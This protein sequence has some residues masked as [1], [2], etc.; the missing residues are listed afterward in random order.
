MKII[1]DKELYL[2][3]KTDL[4]ETKKYADVLKETILNIHT[5]STI[6]LFGEWGSG[7]SSIIKTVQNDLEKEKPNIKFITYDA[8]KYQGDSFR[9]TF[10][11]KVAK[12][13]ECSNKEMQ[14][15]YVNKTQD[16]EI[17]SKINKT[18][19]WCVVV[20]ICII[21]GIC[22]FIPWLF[23][24]LQ[25]TDETINIQIAIS[26]M[27][28]VGLI[29]TFVKN[30][31]TDYKTTITYPLLF[32]PEQFGE[33]FQTIINE[34][35]TIEEN[36]VVIVVDNLDRCNKDV[37]CQMLGDIKGFLEK[38]R[39]VFV[40][41]VDEQA[42][43]H[44]LKTKDYT[45]EC[46]AEEF[47]RKIFDVIVRIKT[48]QT[49]DLFAYI[50]KLLENYSLELKTNTISVIIQEYASNPRR[51]IQFLNNFKMEKGILYKKKCENIVKENEA[52]VALLLI[53]REEWF[54]FYQE[55]SKN[56]K[57]LV[58]ETSQKLKDAPKL[59][60]F[61]KKTKGVWKK[62]DLK[63]M[64]QIIFNL[65]EESRISPDLREKIKD[66][67]L[68]VTKDIS[69]ENF[70]EIMTYL[71]QEL[72]QE[73]KY[74]TFDVG[75]LNLFR[76]FLKIYTSEFYNQLN[77]EDKDDILSK[78]MPILE[79]SHFELSKN[80]DDQE[81]EQFMKF[82][83]HN[84]DMKNLYL[85][86][87]YRK[88]LEEL[89]NAEKSDREIDE[90]WCKKFVVFF[91]RVKIED[92]GDM[93]IQFLRLT[94]RGGIGNYLKLDECQNNG[95]KPKNTLLS[96]QVREDLFNTDISSLDNQNIN[97][98][99]ELVKRKKASINEIKIL[100]D[101]MS[102][103]KNASKEEVQ[104]IVS[105]LESVESNHKESD[106]LIKGNFYNFV[107]NFVSSY[108]DYGLEVFVNLVCELM[109]ICDRKS[110]SDM[111]KDLIK[112]NARFIN[113]STHG[114]SDEN[115]EEI[116]TRLLASLLK[117]N[118]ENKELFSILK[119]LVTSLFVERKK[120]LS[121]KIFD[122]GF[123]NT[124][125]DYT[126]V[127]IALRCG[128][129]DHQNKICTFLD[130][131]FLE[132]K[133]IEQ[134][135]DAIQGYY[136]WTASNRKKILNRLK[137]TKTSGDT[138]KKIA[139]YTSRLEKLERL[140]IEELELKEAY[141]T[142]VV[143]LERVVNKRLKF[144]GSNKVE[145]DKLEHKK[146]EI[147]QSDAIGELRKLEELE[148]INDIKRVYQERSS[149][150]LQSLKVLEEQINS[151]RL[152]I[153]K[154]LRKVQEEISIL[155]TSIRYSVEITQGLNND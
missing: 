139:F 61:L 153:Q 75:A 33:R 73:V 1:E 105:I 12:C 45:N 129:R 125:H 118:I 88:K 124:W 16:K 36:Q 132:R 74:E 121:E 134:N 138:E 68:D 107:Q 96:D 80:L 24:H 113:T 93:D 2:D 19:F 13:F 28:L 20:L 30:V 59:S 32:S 40:I 131:N 147:K 142:K 10:L 103:L 39:V 116:R 87:D 69:Q 154:K 119:D 46:E 51:I 67:S 48:F 9:R 130:H 104:K 41:P 27:T 140:T 4:L 102:G 126:L 144:E 128:N 43:L 15:L 155:K 133:D 91:N 5:P 22:F 149:K 115:E 141:E 54:D 17:R 98:L 29:F 71:L 8:W 79:N 66:M 97:V 56:P 109:R 83:E 146:I 50:K 151:R 106:S 94:Y 60:A 101:K 55:I 95:D 108:K 123:L 152:E 37:V 143:D 86:D 38:N 76:V 63:I 18:Y 26:L 110:A 42:L 65:E 49:R 6:G 111:L 11:I 31:L 14:D 145:L 120:I 89:Y 137:N 44:H 53:L 78:M 57:I 84:R 82:V 70:D 3:D 150:E 122:D 77:S 127:N 81:Y 23:K 25:W 7:K 135:M 92:L 64:E 112:L 90:F 62:A 47:L 21:L 114:N 136:D 34:K 52:L 117:K 99:I 58:N 100:L 85:V 35:T 148:K 72:E